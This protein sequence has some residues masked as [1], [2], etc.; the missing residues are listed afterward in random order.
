MFC[1]QDAQEFSKLF[2]SLLEGQLAQQSDPTVKNLVQG[3]F[4]GEY[5]YVTQYVNC[6]ITMNIYLQILLFLVLLSYLKI[7]C[8]E[9]DKFVFR[10]FQVSRTFFTSGEHIYC[11]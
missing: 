10:L 6:I 7:D 3:L 8:K 9:I 1:L 5:S 2:M 11:Y 4:K